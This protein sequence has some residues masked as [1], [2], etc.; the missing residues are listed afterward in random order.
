L[1]ETA[2]SAY[3]AG[4]V[5][6]ATELLLQEVRAEPADGRK[7]VFLAQLFILSGQWE[8]A[9]NQLSVLKELDA[10]AIPLVHAG[11]QLLQCE[12]L[13]AEV[14]AGRRAPMVLGEPPAWIAQLIQAL[15]A[16]AE[17]RASEAATLRSLA[18]DAATAVQGSLNGEAFEWIADADSRIG[19][20]IEV[21]L[22][23]G[24]YWVPFERI[25]RIV[26]ESPTDIRDL[27]WLPAQ[28]T[29][30]N[31][32]DAIG[33]VP[34][35]YPGSEKGDDSLLLAKRTEWTELGDNGFAGTGQR[36]LVTDAG[37]YGLLDLRQIQ[38]GPDPG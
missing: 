8:R 29:W 27:A 22:D 31:G 16:Q 35:R 21:M 1:P 19:P 13:R 36:M 10:G 24:Y 3:R 18:F 15:T 2:E 17:G 37:E 5:R 28:F 9:A 23:S 38:I 14:F 4:N 11:T 12:R 26:F 32:G 25:R 6:A 7:R 34:T 30:E 33:F 20:V